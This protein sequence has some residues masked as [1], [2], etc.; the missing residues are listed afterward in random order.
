[1]ARD[2]NTFQKQQRE[3][4]KRRKAED[5]RA[6]RQ[7]KRNEA[8]VSEVAAAGPESQRHDTGGLTP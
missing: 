5:K 1:M 8:Q 7:K 4:Q 6:R 2:R 3:N